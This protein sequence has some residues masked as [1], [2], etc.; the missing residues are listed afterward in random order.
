M[1][2][3]HRSI[4]AI[5]L[6][7]AFLFGTASA[8]TLFGLVDTG[9]IFASSD[10][11]ATWSIRATIPVHDAVGL[12]AGTGNLEL[13]MASETGTIYRSPDAGFSWTAVGTI[14]SSD[15][16]D[17]AGLPDDRLL[18][19]DRTG[20]VWRSTDG[21]ASFTGFGAL[22]VSDATSLVSNPL[23]G[24]LYALTRTGDVFKSADG[25]SIWTPVGTVPTSEAVS[26]RRLDAALYV[27]TAS[28]DT[29]RSIDDGASWTAVGTLSQ[30]GV[31]GLTSTGTRLAATT[32]EGEVARSTDG[33]S[34]SWV[35]TI[36]QVHVRALANDIPQV[37]SVSDPAVSPVVMVMAPPSPNP[38][39][40]GQA[41]S[42]QFRLGAPGSVRLDLFDIHGRLVHSH[43]TVTLDNPGDHMLIFRPPSLTSGVYA[44]R[45][46]EGR[47]TAVARQV[48]VVK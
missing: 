37:S 48:V 12:I 1:R 3:I 32:Q 30:V 8:E 2:G 7:G 10:D 5:I 45:L 43:G 26:V 27:V 17:L 14:A 21:G 13:F 23:T 44:L 36:N 38:L 16:V 39:L 18:A 6:P 42:V 24:K 11:G 34:W 47:G 35:G 31:R 40:A 41:V 25:G 20:D 46:L 28:G 9:E 22:S 4:G 29:Y 19:L 15:L 33:S